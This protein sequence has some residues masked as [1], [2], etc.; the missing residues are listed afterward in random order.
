VPNRLDPKRLKSAKFALFV[1][2]F[3]QGFAAITTLPR[4]PELIDQ[5]GVNF[6]QWGAIIGFA[7]L[8]S[9][10]PLV[11]TNKLVNRFG[12]SPVIKVSA[13]AITLV[14]MSLAWITNPI[15]F[16]VAYTLQSFAF[17]TFNIA[18]NA[19]AVM[20]QKKLGK[21]LL[22]SFHGSW[23][24]GAASSAAV[25][26]V[27]ATFLP[28]WLHLV[29]VPILVFIAFQLSGNYLLSPTEDGHEAEKPKAGDKKVSWLAT[30][31]YLWFL[32]LGLWAGMWPELVMMEW[33]AVFSRDVLQLEAGRGALPYTVFVAAMIVGRFSVVHITKRMHFSTMSQW[34]GLIGSVMMAIGVFWS[35]SIV[36][37]GDASTLADRVDAALTVQVVFFALAGLGIASMVPSFYSAAGDIRGLS[38]AQALSRMSLANALMMML[39]KVIMGALAEGPGLEAAF[40]FPILSF[41]AAGIIAG[42]VVKKSIKL[43]AENASAYPPTGPISTLDA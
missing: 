35:S 3:T 28:L 2:F 36:T 11:F 6:A 32:A 23:S 1:I 33:S 13:I 20:F 31:G 15:L 25:S 26:G 29:I 42:V 37:N 22:G 12:T 27:L 17:S 41:L 5:I 30:P 19:Q 8:G 7:G 10:L 21:V 40:V 16:F 14:L 34:G 43:R 24:I 4:I 18:L 9:L 39:A 38:T